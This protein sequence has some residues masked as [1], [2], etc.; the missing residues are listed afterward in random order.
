MSVDV[1]R[2]AVC[3][4]L[5][6]ALIVPR[7]ALACAM[8]FASSSGSVLHA[9]YITAIGLTLLPVLIVAAIAAGISYFRRRSAAQAARVAAPPLGDAA[10]S[11]IA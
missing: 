4:V 5:L 3:A 1:H 10:P 6:A 9:F 2:A 11:R 7:A 8:C